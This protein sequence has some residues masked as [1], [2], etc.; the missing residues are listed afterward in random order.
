VLAAVA[1][2]IAT[3]SSHPAS[4][5]DPLLD[6]AVE[7]TGAV[8]FF[9]TK[10]P[11]L[12]IGVVRNGETSVAGF[13]K[14]RPGE[15]VAPGG[16]TLLRIGSITK[17]FTGA[18]LASL[19]ADGTLKLTDPL[20]KHLGW[21]VQVPTKDGKEIRLID[22]VTHA[23]GLPREVERAPSPPDNPF[24]TITKEAFIVGLKEPLL[25]APGTGVLYSN[26]GFDL[27]AQALANAAGKPY[28][29]LLKERVLEPAG[30]T[31]TAFTPDAEQLSRLMPGHGFDGVLLPVVPTVPMIVGSGGLYST[32][33]DILR[34][35]AWHLDRFATKDAEMRF[36]DHA[37]YVHRD[38]LSPVFGMDESG[39][40]DALGLAWIIMGP[41]EGRP[42]IL[43]KAGGLQGTLS[44]MAFAPS[45]GIGAFV[46]ISQFDFGAA[47]V[48]A[49]V[50]NE[51]IAD[52][53]KR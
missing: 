23:G 29:E 42:L 33:E 15:D 19:V 2:A 3:I 24:Q 25:F 43:Q 1:L 13:G 45:A 6:E 31:S 16:N 10:V 52:L 34:W 12:V 37:A 46:A 44:Y 32:P 17:A 22:L 14:V 7:F 9:E 49:E 5:K 18:V 40:M 35:I 30:L 28:E 41:K 50:V 47:Q 51:L 48:M 26:Y 27:L 4:A 20:Q 8:L 53:A 39:R 11:G 38:G 36:L 21:D